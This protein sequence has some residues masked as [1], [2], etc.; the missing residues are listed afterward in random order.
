ME[1]MLQYVGD[2]MKVRKIIKN[3]ATV[4]LV[5]YVFN[6]AWKHTW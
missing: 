1:I 2:E 6:T 3:T 5:Y 4:L